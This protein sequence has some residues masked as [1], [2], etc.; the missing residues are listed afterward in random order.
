[1]VC[2]RLK[3]KLTYLEKLKN[4]ANFKPLKVVMNSAMRVLL[5]AD[6]DAS[7]KD[8]LHDLRW[9]N[10][11]NMWRWCLIRSL[12]RMIYNWRM[13]PNVWSIIKINMEGALTYNMRY[14]SL[15]LHWTK[16]SRWAQESFVYCAT[17]VYNVLGLHGRLFA[18]YID[19]RDQIRNTLIRHF[20]NLNV[21]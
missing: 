5:W 11:A 14:N 17:D 10:V 19:M 7:M 3:A 20:G 15:K 2:G 18:D 12:Q 16:L 1:M 8:M 21:K 4:K 9:L 6:F 13:V